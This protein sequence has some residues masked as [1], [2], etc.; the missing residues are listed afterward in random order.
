MKH[1]T[2]IYTA[3][4]QRKDKLSL[5]ILFSWLEIQFIALGNYTPSPTSHWLSRTMKRLIPT[6]KMCLQSVVLEFWECWNKEKA[7]LGFK[8]EALWR[9]QVNYLLFKAQTPA[10]ILDQQDMGPQGEKLFR[11]GSHHPGQPLPNFCIIEKQ[12]LSCPSLL[13][14]FR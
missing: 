6:I 10:A 4:L 11:Y 1:L 8:G 2:I 9:F 3:L 5:G 7:D 14:V 12:T 13:S